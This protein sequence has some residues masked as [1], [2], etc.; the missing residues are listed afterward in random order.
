M[1]W[2]QCLLPYRQCSLIE[3]LGL[4]VLALAKVEHGQV[5]ERLRHVWMIGFVTCFRNGNA[6]QC[7]FHGAFKSAA[8]IQIP[9]CCKQKSTEKR[10]RLGSHSV[11]IH[12]CDDIAD[13]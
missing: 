8:V 5:G 13:V 9:S 10:L 2:S 7:K 1:V 4:V 3:W 12:L 11:P 6:D